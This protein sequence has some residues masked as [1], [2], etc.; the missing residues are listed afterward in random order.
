MATTRDS[1]WS[2]TILVMTYFL[3]LHALQ[4]KTGLI[5]LQ[6]HTLAIRQIDSLATCTYSATDVASSDE[7]R[8][9][10]T[11]RLPGPLWRSICLERSLMVQLTEPFE[12][13][14]NKKWSEAGL[15]RRLQRNLHAEIEDGECC[16][17]FR[18]ISALGT[19]EGF[20]IFT[21]D[22]I[23]DPR[24][25]L[26]GLAPELF[27]WPSNC[28]L[29]EVGHY[30]EQLR[31]HLL[32]FIN[33]YPYIE[34]TLL[35]QALNRNPPSSTGSTSP[36][37]TTVPRGKTGPNGNTGPPGKSGAPGKTG[38]QGKTDPKEQS[39]PKGRPCQIDAEALQQPVHR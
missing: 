34:L 39:A 4:T 18:V 35:H 20:P 11:I 15:K 10:F 38:H 28:F 37:G 27:P 31:R 30:H 33:R 14:C 8:Y 22:C 17:R 7:N 29:I 3:G 6:P 2:L 19:G 21:D 5:S 9:D 32:E 12:R 25:Q 16:V 1:V 26:C 13:R 36:T 24:P 23:L